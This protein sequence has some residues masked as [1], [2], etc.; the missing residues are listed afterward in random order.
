MELSLN[1]PVFF[2]ATDHAARTRAFF[3]DA[4]GLRLVADEPF[5]L[6]FEVGGGPLRIQKVEKSEPAAHTVMGWEVDDVH[7]TIR[8]L[9][10][11]GVTFE[12]FEYLEQDGDGV[13]TS[14]GGARV[15]WFKDPCGNL[16]SL[17]QSP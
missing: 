14:P 17:T 2:L 15:A 3:E 12:R 13:W 5:A 1:R 11:R 9:A 10:A 7:R 6:V 16:L 4:L 8:A